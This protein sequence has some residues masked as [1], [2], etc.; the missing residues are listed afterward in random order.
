M[1]GCVVGA[2]VTAR[3]QPC[4]PLHSECAVRR[5][6]QSGGNQDNENLNLIGLLMSRANRIWHEQAKWYVLWPPSAESNVEK[7]KSTEPGFGGRETSHQAPIDTWTEFSGEM[8][9]LPPT[10]RPFV[11]GSLRIG[12]DIPL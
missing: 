6:V 12:R 3:G 8:D 5:T 4:L 9:K 7:E 2:L 11:S 10:D 1:E